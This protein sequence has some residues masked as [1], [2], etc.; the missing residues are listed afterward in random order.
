MPNLTSQDDKESQQD[1]PLLFPMTEADIPEIMAIET[2]C[3]PIPW[4]QGIFADCL[5]VGYSCWVYKP[6][7][8]VLAY[9]ILS[10][11]AEEMHILNLCVHPNE[12]G[13]GIGK[14]LLTQAEWIGT[15]Q[16]A[17]MC[18]LEVRPSNIAAINLY[19]K[20]AYK[21]IGR[22]KNYYPAKTGREDAIVMCK[23]ISCRKSG[24]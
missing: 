19:R 8:N 12:Q 5:R 1:Q 13:K 6:R 2:A 17:K 3:Y 16:Q 21:E 23:K 20:K 10:I 11:A 22:R 7:A 14:L 9:L 24:L 18:F 15:Q 4:T